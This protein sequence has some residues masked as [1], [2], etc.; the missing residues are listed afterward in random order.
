MTD[1]L[2]KTIFERSHCP[3]ACALDQLGDKWSLLIIRDLL[4]GKRRYQEFLTSPEQIATNIL[5]DRLKKL[6]AAGIIVQHAYQ[7]RP[8][9]FEYELTQKGKD[10]RPVLEALVNWGKVYYP[11]ATVFKSHE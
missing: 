6:E 2:N 3:I 10:L 4:L 7:Q 1:N 11:G 9:R 5:A 8:V